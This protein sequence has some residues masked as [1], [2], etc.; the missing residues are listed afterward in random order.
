MAGLLVEAKRRCDALR[1][2][3]RAKIPA[4]ERARLRANY[5][6]IVTV[7]L[8]VNPEPPEAAKR[9]RAEKVGYNLAIAFR[10]HK[11]EILRFVDDLAVSFDNNQSERDLR[12]ARLQTKVSGCFRSE[13]G[14]RSFAAVRSYIE[15][16][17][18]HGANP[19][20]ILVELF[21]HDPWTIPRTV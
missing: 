4:H 10:D 14:A 17:R 6:A 7:A 5:D 3:G 12:M 9:T 16:G 21:E 20:D 15:T 2:A 19:Y 1:A 18:K 11:D 13:R 8:S